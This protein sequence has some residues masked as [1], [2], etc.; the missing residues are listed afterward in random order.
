MYVSDYV[1][2]PYIF[3]LYYGEEDPKSFAET[4]EY[5]N[6]EGAFR[7]VERFAGW[8]FVDPADCPLL[9]LPRWR[10]DDLEVLATYG[11]YSVCSQEVP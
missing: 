11:S 6:P 5:R 10:A 1:S 9:V 8:E 2:A 4:V 7:A 3:A